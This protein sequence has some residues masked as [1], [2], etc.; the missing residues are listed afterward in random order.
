MFMRYTVKRNTHGGPEAVKKVLIVLLHML[1][2]MLPVLAAGP[3]SVE[4]QQL[5]CNDLLGHYYRSSSELED[6]GSH[7]L[8]KY[9]MHTLFDGDTYTGWSEGVSGNGVGETLWLRVPQGTDTL[10]L[11][12]GFAR[13]GRLFQKN[14]RIKELEF[15]LYYALLPEAMVTELGPVYCITPASDTQVIQLKDSPE[16][17]TYSL[18]FDWEGIAGSYDRV[19]G[20][21]PA[22]AEQEGLPP[23]L[24][25]R[26]YL[27]KME[28][29]SVYSGSTW[30]DSCVT[31]LRAFSKNDVAVEKVYGEEGKIMYRV[32]SG[33]RWMLPKVLYHDRSV[34]YEPLELG[35]D[36]RWLTA[37]GTPLEDRGKGLAEYKLFRIPYPQPVT[38]PDFTTAVESGHIPVGF[39]VRKKQVVLLMDNGTEV[40]LPEEYF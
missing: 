16:L 28:I 13:S 23:S 32:D 38:L 22:Y 25:N 20:R 31:E 3:L 39:E 33:G 18:D 11:I 40:L 37:I 35:P 8:G 6:P 36:N 21:Y 24:Q 30:N 34:S 10:A 1:T 27:L 4:F 2:I 26:D 15:S 29:Q 17:E 14:N 5:G 7:L 12:N 9:G 19:A